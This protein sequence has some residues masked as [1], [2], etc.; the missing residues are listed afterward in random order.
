MLQLQI[1]PILYRSMNVLDCVFCKGCQVIRHTHSCVD[2]IIVLG[3]L[4][5]VF[6]RDCYC[7]I[8][9]ILYLSMNLLDCVCL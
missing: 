8:L 2:N 1:L 3:M 5:R 7:K 9:P 4:L 6:M